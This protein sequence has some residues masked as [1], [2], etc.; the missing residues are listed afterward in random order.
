MKLDWLPGDVHLTYC[1]TIHAGESW[2]DTRASLDAHVPAIKSAVAPDRPLVIGLRLS[3]VAAA[4]ARTPDALP[5]FRDQLAQL[6]AYV[7]TI[8]AFPPML[9]L[10]TPL[11]AALPSIA[12]G[13]IVLLAFALLL[14]ADVVPVW[15][16]AKRPVPDSVPRAVSGLIAAIS[17]V[18]ALA[19][20]RAAGDLL[21]VLACA[22]GD[23]LTRLFQASTPG[24]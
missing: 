23:P 3:G 6:G 1:T 17:L 9:L 24:T 7:F 19:V 10:A 18:D 5:A 2:P 11:I 13:R 16:L 22:A 15:L 14:V 4:A 8:N 20:A 21:L 12:S